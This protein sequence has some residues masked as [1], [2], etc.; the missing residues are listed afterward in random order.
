MPRVQYKDWGGVACKIKIA[1]GTHF[2]KVE[3]Y[4]KKLND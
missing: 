1:D 4:M 2:H 3:K